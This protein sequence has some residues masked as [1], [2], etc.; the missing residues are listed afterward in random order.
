MLN[1]LWRKKKS[2][3]LE[4][5]ENEGTKYPNLWD[6]IKAMHNKMFIELC[7][8]KKLE[9]FHTT[10]LTAHLQPE[11][12]TEASTLQRSRWHEIVNR[13]TKKTIQRINKTKSCLINSEIPFYTHHK[14]KDTAIPL[15][16]IYPKDASPCHLKETCSTMF[17]K[18]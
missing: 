13:E 4:F 1:D 6:T 16:G 15:L 2:E 8:F 11:E 14:S 12:E 17:I 9:R 3:F 10:N 7:L 18:P 5:N